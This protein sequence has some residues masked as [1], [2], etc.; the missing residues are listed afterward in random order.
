MNMPYQMVSV[1]LVLYLFF[2]K[3]LI[4]KKYLW[5]AVVALVSLVLI[6]LLHYFINM[7]IF[8][9]MRNEGFVLR[10]WFSSLIITGYTTALALGIK[11]LKYWNYR[12]R[13]IQEL[14]NARL[15]AELKFLKAQIHPHF[16]FN[17]MNNLYT[18]SLKQ[19]KKVPE[20]IEKL[21]DLLRYMAYEVSHPRVALA[22]EIEQLK[23]YMALEKLR[24][25]DKLELSFTV[26]G[27]IDEVKIAPLLLLP[28]V[29]NSFKHGVSGK[30]GSSW[31][32]ISLLIDQDRLHFKVENSQPTG[33]NDEAGYTKGIGLKNVKRRLEL[34]YK[35]QYDL[36]IVNE[37]THL[38]VLKIKLS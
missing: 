34:I 23:N 20:I 7:L 3:L 5:F 27:K 24:Y 13:Y 38:V 10:F 15:E 21:S 1:Y 2:P 19:S 18:L 29:E 37:D 12:E 26:N 4:P 16:L 28:F 9:E 25:G 32:T 6:T 30:L 31:I 22:D 33:I 17:T 36:R 35:D 11:L 14:S 8:P